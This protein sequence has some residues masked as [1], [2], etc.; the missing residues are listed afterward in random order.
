MTLHRFCRCANRTFAPIRHYPSDPSSL[1]TAFSVSST[2]FSA[3]PQQSSALFPATK[4]PPSPSLQSG[5]SAIFSDR[6]SLGVAAPKAFGALTNPPRVRPSKPEK[7]DPIHIGYYAII[8]VA[9]RRQSALTPPAR[10]CGALSSV[11]PTVAL[12]KAGAPER[13]RMP[14]RQIRHLPSSI[15]HLPAVFPATRRLGKSDMLWFCGLNEAK[16]KAKRF[17]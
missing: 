3:T 14:L 7:S 1:P 4:S 16:R 12:A 2:N 17:V 11:L 8:Y 5:P 9:A 6:A 15:F 10:S 13:R